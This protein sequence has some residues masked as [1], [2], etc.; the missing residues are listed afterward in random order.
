MCWQA[1]E[2]KD[3]THFNISTQTITIRTISWLYHLDIRKDQEGVK[4]NNHEANIR[5]KPAYLF[6]NFDLFPFRW[7]SHGRC[8]YFV[9][10]TLFL[11]LLIIYSCWCCFSCCIYCCSWCC[12][13][14]QLHWH[15]RSVDLIVLLLVFLLVDGHL[16]LGVLRE[17]PRTLKVNSETC[18]ASFE[19]LL[20]IQWYK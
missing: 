13:G 18:Q 2:S 20:C 8:V 14:G 7:Y 6:F 1:I 15:M 9:F 16:L 5:K 10:F 19:Y 12:W 4:L 17:R 3:W 11:I